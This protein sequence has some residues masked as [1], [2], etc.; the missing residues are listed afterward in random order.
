MSSNTLPA[1]SES[2]PTTIPVVS[3]IIIS[4]NTRDLLDQCLRSIFRSPAS[5]PYEVLVIDNCSC[6]QSPEMVKDRYPAVRLIVNQEN[7]GFAAANNQGL[8]VARGRYALLLN[9]D[10]ELLGDALDEMWRHFETHAQTGIVGSKLL[11]SDGSLQPSGNKIPTLGQEIIRVLP[12]GN[13]KNRYFDPQRNYDVVA[14]VEEVS[15]ACLMLR[16]EV[17]ESV[18]LLDENFFF[19][20]EDVDLCRRARQ[21]GWQVKYLPT[22]QVLHHSQRSTP[23]RD[24]VF[25][26]RCLKGYFYWIRK[27]YGP[28][29]ELVLRLEMTVLTASKLLIGSLAACCGS[30]RG[31]SL[32][33]VSRRVL[34]VCLGNKLTGI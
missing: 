25:A 24:P 26:A 12:F 29:G 30:S 21:A 4:Y 19:Y 16:R 20:H 7:V 3:I 1:A 34:P 2:G 27:C 18:G 5:V 22:A 10:T 33:A 14:D 23:I 28:W 17:W 13:K 31:R 6:D 11:N 8:R 15:G 9:S 32:Q